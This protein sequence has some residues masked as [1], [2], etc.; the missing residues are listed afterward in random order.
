MWRSRQCG[1][2]LSAAP[3]AAGAAPTVVA[4]VWLS[5]TRRQSDALVQAPGTRERAWCGRSTVSTTISSPCSC[6]ICPTPLVHA[7]WVQHWFMQ[8]LCTAA[9]SACHVLQADHLLGPCQPAVAP[10]ARGAA[11]GPGVS[12]RRDGCLLVGPLLWCA[13]L[14]SS[15]GQGCGAVAGALTPPVAQLRQLWPCGVAA[16][17]AAAM[18]A[19]VAMAAE[20]AAAAAAAA[21]AATGTQAHTA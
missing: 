11:S 21:C 8:L 4:L 2:P 13:A 1:M 18:A 10:I 9:S 15:Q 19:K 14:H 7:A 20:P 17:P 5:S 3:A 6:C 16:M 12:C